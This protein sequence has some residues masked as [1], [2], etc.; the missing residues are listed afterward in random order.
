MRTVT[1]VAKADDGTLIGYQLTG[2]GPAILLVHGAAADARQWSMIM[3]LLAPRFTVVAMDRRGR[4]SSGP[5]GPDHSLKVECGDIVAVTEAI[6]RPVH[7]VGHSSGAR[8]A[9][10]AALDM[11]ELASLTLYEPPAPEHF[12]DGV[13]EGLAELEKA[14]D[15]EGILRS[16]LVDIAGND[17]E[18]FAFIQ[19][20]PIWPIMVDNALTLPAELRAVSD[21]R[22]D[23]GAFNDLDV[24]A[25]C[26]LGQLSGPELGRVAAEVAGA[27]PQARVVTLAGQAH[28]A[29]ISAPKLFASELRRFFEAVDV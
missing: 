25:L 4:G 24:P 9:L 10:H 1:R 14:G 2:N 12:D 6:D 17:E 7:L 11:S 29:M 3:P 19:R 21:Y 16:F 22:F 8:F 18:A 13:L 20:R 27:L 28:G 5:I 23:P 26:L 15:R